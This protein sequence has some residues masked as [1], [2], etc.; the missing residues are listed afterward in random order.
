MK[1]LEKVMSGKT[2]A[3]RRVMLYGTHGIGKS[4]FASSAPNPV[5]L[6]TEDGLGEIDCDKFPVA[7]TFQGKGVFPES[8]PLF[9]WNGFGAAAAP[10]AR[11]VAER[12]RGTLAIGCRFG[13]VGT[14]R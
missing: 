7:T 6:Q 10:F 2:P 11:G 1:L 12:R 9:L 4:T 3:P 14:G 8:H 13:E 5:F